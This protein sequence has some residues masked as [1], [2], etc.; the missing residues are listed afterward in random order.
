MCRQYLDIGCEFGLP[1]LMSTPTWRASRERIDA[2]GY[3]GVDVNG[4]NVRFLDALRKSYGGYAKE[5]IICGLMSCRG[6]A[7]N[8]AEALGVDE[9]LEFHAWQAAPFPPS[10]RR[11][12]LLW[13]L[14][15]PPSHTCSVSLSVPREPYWTARP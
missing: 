5:V 8:P 15:P 6:D 3:S 9:A 13:P 2:A 10:A 4:D 11:P 7:Y 14:Q 12:A 1:L